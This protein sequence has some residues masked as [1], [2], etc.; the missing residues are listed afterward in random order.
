ML[1][2]LMYSHMAPYLRP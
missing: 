1:S 2:L